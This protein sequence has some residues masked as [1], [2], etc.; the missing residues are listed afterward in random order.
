M[1]DALETIGLVVRVGLEW[2]MFEPV[3]KDGKAPSHMV[4]VRR[5]TVDARQ[6][7]QR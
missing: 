4:V 2:G 1:H 7:V 3:L 5:G 6:K